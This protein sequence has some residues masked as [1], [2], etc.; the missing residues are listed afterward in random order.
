VAE[1]HAV[2]PLEAAPA[3]AAAG[4]RVPAAFYRFW[5][6][7]GV[8]NL[9]DGAVYAG[10][11]L[12][13]FSL[14]KDAF[15]VAAV[16]TALR[17]PAVLVGVFTG[18]VIDRFDLRRIVG[19]VL[20]VRVGVLAAAATMVAL[21]AAS[22][23]ALIGIAFVL[24]ALEILF[25]NTSP[26]VTP[27]L[28]RRDDLTWANG[29]IMA[30]QIVA[31]GI[32][33]PPLGALL[34]GLA[35]AF[36]FWM[37]AGAYAL[38][39]AAVAGIRTQ[40]VAREDAARAFSRESLWAG[41]THV[42]HDSLLRRF[43]IVIPTASFALT[44]ALATFV[45]LVRHELGVSSFGYGVVLAVGS[46]GGVAGA[47]V[48]PRLE[49]RLGR[50]RTLPLAFLVAGAGLAVEGFA[51]NVLVLGVGAALGYA[52]TM[53]WGPVMVGFLQRVVPEQ[54]FGRVY[55]GYTAAQAAAAT[56]GA[57]A[58]GAV[59][60]AFNVRVTFVVSAMLFGAAGTFI[61]TRMAKDIAAAE[62]AA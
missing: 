18:A 12:L 39:L 41:L 27:H 37:A 22:I 24:G 36:P 31:N 23:G 48:A 60:S 5:S 59:A 49:A 51:P 30:T 40:R 56:I 45:I 34:F 50:Q 44:A 32:L 62:A 11:P 33:G 54:V 55:A 38:A 2:P 52:G 14:T 10:L 20:A 13:A 47:T 16:T 28:V 21:H 25:D 15:V 61:A 53:I 9:G 17:M 26:A 29:R 42:W 58:G 35:L 43:L 19:S 8:S 7:V 3:P 46:I 57:A 4:G 6:A 1:P